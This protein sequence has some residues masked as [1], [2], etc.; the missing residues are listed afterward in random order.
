M[1]DNYLYSD[2]TGEVIAAFYKVYNALHYGFLEKVYENA[3]AFELKKAG[4]A[5]DQQIS[6]EVFYDGLKVGFYIADM[7]VDQKLMIEIKS[8]EMLR[9]EHEAQLTNYLRATQ[10]EV[11]LLLNFGKEPE[12][13]RKVFKNEHKNHLRP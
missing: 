9:P 8:A 5:V 13:K 2:L 7:V 4:F 11:G 6:I 12:L 10:I 1:Y 3:L